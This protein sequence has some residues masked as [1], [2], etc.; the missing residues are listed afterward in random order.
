MDYPLFASVPVTPIACLIIAITIL[1]GIMRKKKCRNDEPERLERIRLT[2][3]LLSLTGVTTWRWRDQV[4]YSHSSRG[5]SIYHAKIGNAETIE[6]YLGRQRLLHLR[7]VE[8]AYC[9]D[10]PL[11]PDEADMVR[12]L[13][14]RL[15]QLE[16]AFGVGT[17]SG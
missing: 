11:S 9:D 3:E 7:Y 4:S 17:P 10:R 13:Q 6:V 1:A 8:G 15:W 14:N 5:Y 12:E 2:K 16:S